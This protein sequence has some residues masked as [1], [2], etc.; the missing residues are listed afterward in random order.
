M[1]TKSLTRRALPD[2][3]RIGTVDQFQGEATVVI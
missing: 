2:G 1:T 3:V